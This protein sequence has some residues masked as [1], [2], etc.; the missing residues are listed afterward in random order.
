MKK[1]KLCSILNILYASVLAA[2]MVLCLIGDIGL[3]LD[4]INAIKYKKNMGEYIVNVIFFIVIILITVLAISKLIKAI[5][6]LKETEKIA[7]L[8]EDR[9]TRKVI[10]GNSIPLLLALISSPLVAAAALAV[11]N[12]TL[13]S[14]A[15][16]GFIG[17]LIAIAC[18]IVFRFIRKTCVQ[19]YEHELVKKQKEAK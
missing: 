17:Y 1:L 16:I 14:I 12:D 9:R 19:I 11:R 6:E 15:F 18:S 5:K 8:I 7:Q 10:K 13:E 4:F 2:S 3:V